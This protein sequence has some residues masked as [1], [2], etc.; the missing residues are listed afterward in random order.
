MVD[1]FT[2]VKQQH[3]ERTSEFL[4]KELKCISQNESSDRIFFVSALEVSS[5]DSFC[6]NHPFICILVLNTFCLLTHFREKKI[7]FLKMLN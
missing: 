1:W 6:L 4:V 7:K 3:M 5:D 2:Q